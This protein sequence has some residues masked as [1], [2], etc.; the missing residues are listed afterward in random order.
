MEHSEHATNDKVKKVFNQL[1]ELR[2]SIDKQK[3]EKPYIITAVEMKFWKE[4]YDYCLDN[5]FAVYV[6]F[7]GIYKFCCDK[8][9]KWQE[10]NL[11]SEYENVESMVGSEFVYDNA[12]FNRDD[13]GFYCKE[14]SAYNYIENDL[15]S[16]YK[17][18]AEDR[19]KF[20]KYCVISNLTILYIF[21]LDKTIHCGS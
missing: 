17:Y 21:D 1:R 12:C 10:A 14:C 11:Q 16:M 19:I 4:I 5:E 15:E 3:K 7:K 2:M 9:G 20:D 8:C 18:V 6:L 13:Y